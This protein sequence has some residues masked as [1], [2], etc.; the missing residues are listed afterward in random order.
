MINFAYSNRVLFYRRSCPYDSEGCYKTCYSKGLRPVIKHRDY[1]VKPSG[2]R[3]KGASDFDSDLYKQF[4]G[5]V[6]GV[7][8]GLHS[9]KTPLLEI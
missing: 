1:G 5:I 7:F 6:E 9:I 2:F 8:G 4:R 3:K